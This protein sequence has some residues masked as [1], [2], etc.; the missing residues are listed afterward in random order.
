MLRKVVGFDDVCCF[1]PFQ[2]HLDLSFEGDGD[3][4]G[5]LKAEGLSV[6]IQLN[7]DRRAP[8]RF[9]VELTIDGVDDLL[10]TFDEVH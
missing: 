2:F 1:H 8:H 3:P 9:F 6:F 7:V 4:P 10:N 5:C